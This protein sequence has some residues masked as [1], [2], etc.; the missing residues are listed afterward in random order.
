LIIFITDNG[1]FLSEHGLGKIIQLLVVNGKLLQLKE[2][3]YLR[4]AGKWFPYQES[5]RVP[6]II[7]DPP[8]PKHKCNTLDD[9]FTFNIDL[10]ETILG[11]AGVKPHARMQ[12]RNILELYLKPNG[13]E[14]WHNEFFYQFRFDKWGAVRPFSTALV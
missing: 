11:A 7:R 4:A 8:M 3:S 13:R 6:L 14:S 5:I 1:Y 10:A 12:G 2:M 9:S